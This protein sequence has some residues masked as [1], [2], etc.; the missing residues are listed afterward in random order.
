MDVDPARA[1]AMQ[2]MIADQ[3]NNLFMRNPL[4]LSHLTVHFQEPPSAA[5]ISYQELTVDKF[6][7]HYLIVRE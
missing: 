1:K 4:A 6:V 2:P 3:S 7:P 5:T